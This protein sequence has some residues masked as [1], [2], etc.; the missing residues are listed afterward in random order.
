[1]GTSVSR[2]VVT[3]DCLKD[4]TRLIKMKSLQ[5][6]ARLVPRLVATRTCV[7]QTRNVSMKQ[8]YDTAKAA[9]LYPSD[10]GYA[11]VRQLQIEM[12]SNP[13]KMVWQKRG[14]MDSMPMMITYAIMFGGLAYGFSLLWTMSWPKPVEE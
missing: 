4:V 8:P 10:A 12:N 1:M 5:S 2:A 6:A 7:N 11:R 13:E 14:A 9:G 3:R